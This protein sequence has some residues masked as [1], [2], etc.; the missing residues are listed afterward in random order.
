MTGRHLHTLMTVAEQPGGLRTMSDDEVLV[1]IDSV[2]AGLARAESD[3][4]G[5]SSKARRGWREGLEAAEVEVAHRRAK[6]D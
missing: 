2:R 3:K 5:R 1:W 4:T 6:D